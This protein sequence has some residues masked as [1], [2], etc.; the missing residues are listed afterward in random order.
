MLVLGA[1]I[2][3]IFFQTERWLELVE[4]ARFEI[5][6]SVQTES[7]VRI[8]PSPPEICFRKLEIRVGIKKKK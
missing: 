4:G 5:E 2:G 1:C 8:P 3:R 6:Y 7:R